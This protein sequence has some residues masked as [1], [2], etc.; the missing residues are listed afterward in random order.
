MSDAVNFDNVQ[1]FLTPDHI[2]LSSLPPPKVIEELSFGDIFDA[3]L[4]DFKKRQPAYDALLESD[5]VIIALECAAYR[6][7][8]LRNRIN[9]AAKANMLA[10]AT[11]GDLDNLAAFYGV[12]R[13]EDESDARLRYRAQL[14]LESLTTAGSEKAY[15]FHV[16]SASPLIKSA[17]VYSPEPGQVLIS[18]LS[19]EDEGIADEDLIKAVAKYVSSE[20]KRPLTDRVVVQSA[21]IKEYKISAKVYLYFSPSMAIT[22]QECREALDAYIAKKNTIGNIVARSGIFNALHT[23][24]VR[25]VE[26]LKP[27]TDIETTKEQAPKCSEIN[28][29]F[30]IANDT[31]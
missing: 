2:D 5:P 11:E 1:N 26:L 4:I 9:E 21:E 20:E 8:L 16:L 3:L 10:Y 14:A 27:T 7:T 18:I 29:E 13:L 31:D 19:T 24:G 22:E 25:K 15:L 23:E 6:E 28:L 17:S 30:V 12:E